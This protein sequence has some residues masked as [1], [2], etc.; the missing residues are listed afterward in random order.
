MLAIFSLIAAVALFTG[1]AQA[2][3]SLLRFNAT[4]SWGERQWFALFQQNLRFLAAFA[5]FAYLVLPQ[6][7]TS[8]GKVS[9][10]FASVRFSTLHAAGSLLPA[11]LLVY[12]SERL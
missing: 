12:L 1:Y 4:A 2:D 3:T 5:F 9:L 11:A 10:Y 7:E 6:F 8:D